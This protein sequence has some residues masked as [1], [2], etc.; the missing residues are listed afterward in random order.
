MH[1]IVEILVS[2]GVLIYEMWSYTSLFDYSSADILADFFILYACKL[3]IS[4]WI[5]YLM[6][7]FFTKA[8][9]IFF[10]VASLNCK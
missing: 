9:N 5:F 8:S 6:I 7:I 4:L 1:V 2:G 3:I 10:Y